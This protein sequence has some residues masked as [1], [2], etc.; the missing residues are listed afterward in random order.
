M[1]SRQKGDAYAQLLMYIW[2]DIVRLIGIVFLRL[3]TVT[4][5]HLVC[6][7]LCVVV[8]LKSGHR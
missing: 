3:A 5:A 4:E 1:V 2:T 7:C 6:L 8:E